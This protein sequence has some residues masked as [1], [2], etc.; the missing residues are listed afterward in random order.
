MI[1]AS[2]IQHLSAPLFHHYSCA[3]PLYLKQSHNFTILALNPGPL[4]EL[5]MRLKWCMTSCKLNAWPQ[6]CKYMS[7]YWLLLGV[8]PGNLSHSFFQMFF[9]SLWPWPCLRLVSIQQT[10]PSNQRMR[11]HTESCLKWSSYRVKGALSMPG[12]A[13]RLKSGRPSTD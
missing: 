9:A 7:V 8:G 13:R 6:K 5:G 11:Q 4:Y 2:V 1:T 12:C 10:L 3:L